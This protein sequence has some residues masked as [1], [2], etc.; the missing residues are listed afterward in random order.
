L[1][2]T[3]VLGGGSDT[4]IFNLL[5]SKDANGGNGFDTW[6]DFTVGNVQT[7]SNADKIDVSALLSGAN[8]NNISSYISYDKVKGV[9]SI[10]RDG[11]GNQYNPTE[12]L[13]I[14]PQSSDLT[15]EQ[16]LQNGQIIY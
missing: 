9:I 14:G 12:L 13:N 6:S 15:L 10:D 11:A 3:F 7:N 4:L 8:E 1:D 16:L 2:D 5:K